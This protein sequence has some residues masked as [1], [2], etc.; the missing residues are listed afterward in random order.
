MLA[1]LVRVLVSA[2]D[3][4]EVYVA[5]V[6]TVVAAVAVVSEVASEVASEAVTVGMEEALDVIFPT[7]ISMLTILAR[8]NMRDTVA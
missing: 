2:V 3:S 4:V 7:R 5:L 1:C 8:T 6:A